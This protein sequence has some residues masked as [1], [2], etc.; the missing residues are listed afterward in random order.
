MSTNDIIIE[1]DKWL[2]GEGPAMHIVISSRS[3]LARNV[4]GYG[5]SPFARK[6]ELHATADAAAHA[7]EM[8]QNGKQFTRIAVSE[9]K[10]YERHYLTESHLISKE[11]GKNGEQRYVYLNADKTVSI[12]VNEEDHLRMQCLFPGLQIPETFKTINS[13]DNQLSKYLNYAF[14][15]KYGYLTACP[16]NTGTGLR[17]SVMVHLPGLAVQDKIKEIVE[18]VQPHNIAIRGLHGES[19]S[20]EG[21][22]YQISNEISLGKSEEDIIETLQMVIAQIIEREENA[23]SKLFEEHTMVVEDIIWRSFALLGNARRMDSTEAL[24]LLSRIRLGIDREL[25]KNLTHQ[26]LNRMIIEIQP[27]HLQVNKGEATPSS[28]RDN[29]RATFLREKFKQIE[30]FN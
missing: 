9:L 20:F 1:S 16:T 19:S 14:S 2:N 7:L 18:I 11:L 24:Q 13:I 29:L 8:I 12:M 21:D 26:K 30:S 5:Y 4:E 10:G 28:V 6:E 15:D 22:F 25:F 3:R 27:G 23:R 17:V